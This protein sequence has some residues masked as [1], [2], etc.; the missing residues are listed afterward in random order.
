MNNCTIVLAAGEGTRMHVPTAKVLLPVLGKPMVSWVLT[1]ARAAGVEDCCLIVGRSG[2]EVRKKV[3]DK[4]SYAVQSERLGTGHAVMQATAFLEAHRGAHCL[5]LAGDCPL[6]S[7]ETISEAFRCHL[8]EGNAVTV[9]SARVKDPFGYGRIV[10]DVTGG[11]LRIV[12][13]KDADADERRIDEIN[14]SAYWFETDAL[15]EALPRIQNDNAKGEYYLTDA[16]ELLLRAG[17][18]AGVSVAKDADEILGANTQRQLLA[19]QRIAQEKILDRHMEN[20]V[21]FSGEDGVLVGPDVT[22]GPGTVIHPG[23]RLLGDTHLGQ[24]CVIGP[25][26]ILEDSRVGDGAQI[27]SST[28]EQSVVGDLARIGPYTHIRPNSVIGERCKLGNFVE[29]KNSV[30]GAGTSIAHLTYVGDAD[31]G[32]RCNFGCGV[33]TT[34]YDGVKKYRT[35][36]GDDVFIG[37]NV[38]LVAPVT[39]EDGAYIAAG[40]TITHNVPKSSL[41]IA[42]ARQVIKDNWVLTTREE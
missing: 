34:N 37:C 7:A 33:V 31:V 41:A 40:S 12:E 29:V 2:D 32:C 42:R 1:A 5:V 15:L 27:R 39:V 38:N 36:V 3:G 20:G 25:D 23:S 21:M 28:I 26:A 35:T 17:R 19:L 10:R 22:I 13:E 14:S 9:I 16:I 30:I 8:Q 4:V 11:L 24:N 18:R 6:L